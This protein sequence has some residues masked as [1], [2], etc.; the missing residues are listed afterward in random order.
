[1]IDDKLY[2]QEI[3]SRIVTRRKQF[4]LSQEKLAAKCNVSPQFISNVELGKRAIHPQNLLKLSDALEVSADYLLSGKII[5]KDFFI[6]NE[7]IK[8]L[9]PSQLHTIEIII[10]DLYLN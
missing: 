1:M 7:K 8:N 10:Y 3:G 9:S 5:E 6:F 4:K 2:L